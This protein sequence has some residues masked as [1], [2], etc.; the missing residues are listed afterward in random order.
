MKSMT[1]KPYFSKVRNKCSD[2]LFLV[3][4]KV[5]SVFLPFTKNTIKSQCQNELCG[6][7]SPVKNTDSPLNAFQFPWRHVWLTISSK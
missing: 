6:T 3:L 7:K 4:N 5:L 1:M 2:F